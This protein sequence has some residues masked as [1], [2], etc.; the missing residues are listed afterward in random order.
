M[1]RRIEELLTTGLTGFRKGFGKARKV[2]SDIRSELLKSRLKKQMEVELEAEFMKPSEVTKEMKSVEEMVDVLG[3]EKTKAILGKNIFLRSYRRQRQ[4]ETRRIGMEQPTIPIE[5][6]QEFGVVGQPEEEIGITERLIETRPPTRPRGLLGAER[7][8]KIAEAQEM[9]RIKTEAKGRT[10]WTTEVAERQIKFDVLTPKLYNYMEVGGRAYQELRDTAKNFGID[11]NFE[12]GGINA[13]LA[14]GTKSVAM[15]AKL[16]PLMVAL[17]RLR[18]EL[19][20]ELMRQLGAFRSA[21]MA[22]R[23]AATLAQFSGDLREDIANMS[24]TITKNKAN[25]VLLDEFGRRLP[26]EE[27][28]RRMD[29]FEA[30]L[31][32]KYNYM[33][34]GMGLMTKPYTA[35]RSFE[36]L[37]KNSTFNEG[38]E[39]L[40]QN[41]MYDNPKFTRIQITAQL[42]K[43]GIL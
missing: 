28:N 19:G 37:A 11:L 35:Q 23:F 5:P 14:A 20:T 24:T 3:I 17:E 6:T 29:A 36:W 33:Y 31:V 38:E 30:N 25:T 39:Q 8:R 26:D 13:L 40:I 41:A 15:K 9:E 12:R 34:R 10:K 32:R 7:T 21:A 1:A 22:Q 42:I 16:A 27:R 4:P 2:E 18:P 43:R